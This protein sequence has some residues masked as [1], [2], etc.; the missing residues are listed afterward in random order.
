M[1]RESIDF[2][3][4]SMG[5]ISRL[6]LVAV[7]CLFALSFTQTAH[8]RIEQ[9]GRFYHGMPDVYSPFYLTDNPNYRHPCVVTEADWF[10][11]PATSVTTTSGLTKMGDGTLTI[12]DEL[13]VTY[14]GDSTTC[15]EMLGFHIPLNNGILQSLGEVLPQE[16]P[17]TTTETIS[18]TGTL[19]FVIDDTLSNNLY[20][21]DA[22]LQNFDSFAIADGTWTQSVN[23]PVWASTGPLTISTT[24]SCSTLMSMIS[25]TNDVPLVVFVGSDDSNGVITSGDTI[26][27][28]LG[29]G[30][31]CAGQSM[32][33]SSVPEPSVL[34]LLMA[35]FLGLTAIHN[36]RPIR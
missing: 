28:N 23:D 14:T 32:P 3:R 17:S 30:A 18:I 34:S 21:Q 11:T 27:G 24:S 20:F 22:N 4:R 31:A 5:P 36:R 35:L 8:A 6:V 7:V 29:Q 13:N 33:P 1:L 15:A 25:S 10:S 26:A 19:S 16:R 2:R 9:Y 12:S